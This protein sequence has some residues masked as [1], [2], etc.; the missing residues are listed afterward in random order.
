[1]YSQQFLLRIILLLQ[2]SLFSSQISL[3]QDSASAAPGNSSILGFSSGHHWYSNRDEFLSES[4]YSGSFTPISIY[5]HKTH[6]TKGFRISTDVS[7]ISSLQTEGLPNLTASVLQ[8]EIMIDHWYRILKFDILGKASTLNIGPGYGIRLYVR[9]QDVAQ[10]GRLEQEVVSI[11][12]EIP[13]RLNAQLFHQMS[14]RLILQLDFSFS[15]LAAS[16]RS[17]LSDEFSAYVLASYQNLDVAL[18]ATL[19]YSILPRLS[20]FL[21]IRNRFTRNTGW[22]QNFQAGQSGVE[23]GLAYNF[24]RR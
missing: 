18:D 17:D 5:W 16:L 9:T 22:N 14:T 23:M 7:N 2:F 8:F 13:L 21:T 11:F 6:E 1:M 4:R 19:Y 15:L 20:P 3:S 24:S 12:E 10:G